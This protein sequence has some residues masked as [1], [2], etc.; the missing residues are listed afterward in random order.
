[1]SDP[2]IKIVERQH[3]AV[4]ASGRECFNYG[5]TPVLLPQV[6]ALQNTD[7]RQAWWDGLLAGIV[8][9]MIITIGEAKTQE[10]CADLFTR[11][12]DAKSDV[13]RELANMRK[14]R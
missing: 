14:G 4:M 8:E 7:L 9:A 13:D 1:M 3:L 6:N 10:V 5:V 11:S 2:R 12:L